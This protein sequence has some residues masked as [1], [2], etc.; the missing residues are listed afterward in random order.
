[1]ARRVQ[2]EAAQVLPNKGDVSTQPARQQAYAKL[3]ANPEWRER[4][5]AKKRERYHNDLAFR[6]TRRA[7]AKKR[8]SSEG[9]VVMRDI[10]MGDDLNLRQKLKGSRQIILRRDFV[11]RSRSRHESIKSM[12]AIKRQRL[13][14]RRL[15]SW[16]RQRG[17][18]RRLV[19]FDKY[20]QPLLPRGR[21]KGHRPR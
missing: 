15:R 19:R 12:V 18:Y 4:H 11:R 9:I 5:N 2:K 14:S 3:A 17:I 1:M 10:W 8:G 16:L 13:K 20:G 6:V 7:R 21:P